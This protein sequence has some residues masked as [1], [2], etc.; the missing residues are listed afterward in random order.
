MRDG[1]GGAVSIVQRFGAALNLNVHVHAL[2]LDG[3]FADDATGTLAFHA[4]GPPSDE[5][6]TAVIRTV[7]RRVWRLLE[8]RGL[9]EA[10]DRFAAPDPLA[11]EAPVLAGI[12]AASVTGPIALAPRAGARVRRCGEP[13]DLI[14]TAARGPRHAHLEGF[15]L[16]ANVAAPAGHRA[17]LE[18]VCH[19]ALR[20]PIAQ[21]RLRR[22]HDGQILLQLR[23]RWTD[24][25]THLLFDPV[26]LFERLAALTLRRA[27]RPRVRRRRVSGSGS[28]RAVSECPGV[29][30]EGAKRV[31]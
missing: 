21:E 4:L 26:E 28:I 23:H 18:R 22:T 1:R 13:G 2:V 11:E 15:D 16:H 20:P 17:R 14:D 10:P 29:Q 19:Y 9:A 12:H 25:T 7:R 24:G 8:R 27:Q 5:E 3:V 31:E 30:R 6:V